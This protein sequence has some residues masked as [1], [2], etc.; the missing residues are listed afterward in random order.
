MK[1]SGSLPQFENS[2]FDVAI[3]VDDPANGFEFS[4]METGLDGSSF[5]EVD[6]IQFSGSEGY[7]FDQ[8][9]N[10]FGGYQS[11]VPFDMSIHYDRT[12]TGF[13]YYFQ[14]VLVANNLKVNT[15]VLEERAN[16]VQFEKYGNSTLSI[17]AEGI[18]N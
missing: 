9:G 15:G 6:L 18:V 3:V 8:S 16:I 4:I 13:K 7:L 10:Y 2:I 17:N 12:T 11:G 1:V 5:T 14:D